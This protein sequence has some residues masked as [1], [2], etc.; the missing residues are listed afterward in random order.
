[1]TGANTVPVDP[2]SAVAMAVGD[3]FTFLDGLSLGRPDPTHQGYV[4]PFS[5]ALYYQDQQNQT[6]Q[7][8]LTAGVLVF[9][10][11]AIIGAWVL[12]KKKK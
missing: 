5:T 8:W 12:L 6:D 3:I 7:I 1:M 11:A 2:V 10:V 4:S 9:V